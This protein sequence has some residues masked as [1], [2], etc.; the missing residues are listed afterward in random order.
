VKRDRNRA[1]DIEASDGS[2][3]TGGRLWSAEREMKS[4][5]EIKANETGERKKM[6]VTS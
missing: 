3:Y 6:E 4:E 5:K 2:H 1:T